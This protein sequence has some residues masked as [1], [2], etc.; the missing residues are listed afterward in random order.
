SKYSFLSLFSLLIV[1]GFNGYHYLYSYPNAFLII[2]LSLGENTTRCP[3]FV[4]LNKPSFTRRSTVL[5]EHRSILATSFFV[6]IELCFMI[7]DSIFH[8]LTRYGLLQPDNLPP[9]H[10]WLSGTCRP[11]I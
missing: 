1:Y 9:H 8:R 2:V 3:F 6:N 10:A 7:F 11:R 4:G 5:M